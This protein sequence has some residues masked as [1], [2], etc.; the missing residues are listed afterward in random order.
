MLGRQCVASHSNLRAYDSL[1]RALAVE[2]ITA[3]NDYLHMNAATVD[4]LL[5][6]HQCEWCY[7]NFRKNISLFMIP[8]DRQLALVS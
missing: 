2:D 5:H 3:Y 4:D 7:T 6:G 8:C 1:L